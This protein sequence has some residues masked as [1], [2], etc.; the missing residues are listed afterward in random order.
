M[1]SVCVHMHACVCASMCESTYVHKRVCVCVCVCVCGVP[2]HTFV[3][4][5]GYLAEVACLLCHVG[6]AISP[7]F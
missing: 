2:A 7:G 5:S 6:P 1:Y 3:I 4:A